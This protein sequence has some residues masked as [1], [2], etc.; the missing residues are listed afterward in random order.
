MSKQFR[1]PPQ[2]EIQDTDTDEFASSA[3]VQVNIPG[4]S[5]ITSHTFQLQQTAFPKNIALDNHPPEYIKTEHCHF[6]HSKD[7]SGK[8]HTYSSP[9]GGHFHE[10]EIRPNPNGQHL[11]PVAVCKSGPL[12]WAVKKDQ[13]GRKKKIVVPAWPTVETDNEEVQW[14]A[15]H[16]HKM[17][18]LKTTQ[19]RSRKI[20]GHATQALSQL[21]KAPPVPEGVQV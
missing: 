6:F 4:Q 8:T 2:I 19:V 10:I 17:M 11:P 7:S 5:L 16:K 3:E 20:S 18:Y 1:R 9:V 21:D 12:K 13:Y 14:A 15:E